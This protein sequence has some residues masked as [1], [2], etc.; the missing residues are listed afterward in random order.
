[1]DIHRSSQNQSEKLAL[2]CLTSTGHLAHVNSLGHRRRSR[3]AIVFL[4]Q[5]LTDHPLHNRGLQNLVSLGSP[6]VVP[7]QQLGAQH[8][9]LAAVPRRNRRDRRTHD[10]G[11]QLRE[12]GAVERNSQCAELI[13]NHTH[14]PNISGPSIRSLLAHLRRKVIRGTDCR[15][16]NCSG[17]FHD[18]GNT[19]I[20]NLQGTIGCQKHVLRLEVA[21]QH[22]PVVCILERQESL[23]H[24]LQQLAFLKLPASSARAVNGPSQI[25]TL[26]KI[27]NNAQ[28]LA[29]S[30]ALV[31]RDD[32][33]VS[34]SRQNLNLFPSLT[35]A[36]RA[37]FGKVHLLHHQLCSLFVLHQ[38][39]FSETS[40]S[41]L[42][43]S[44]V[45]P[46]HGC[47]RWKSRMT[48]A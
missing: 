44:C 28:G 5:H 41:D 30:E 24:P 45:R 19:K 29:L 37:Q 21:V 35:A 2:S 27:H 10:I 31:K 34:Q 43:D 8:L 46:N 18:F 14:G 3:S 9:D 42:L 47:Q 40:L 15:L 48:Q 32:V 12:V 7:R 16:R 4:L 33:R 22:M 25:A 13:E 17:A 20:T 23:R 26:G 6:F 1:M 11:N 39:A 38:K 36:F